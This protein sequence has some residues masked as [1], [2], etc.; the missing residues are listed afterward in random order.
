MSKE[1]EQR[2]VEM[3]F[4]NKQ[5]EQNVSTTMST[6]DKLKQKL[7]FTGASKG[8]E[9]ISSA[10]KKID[11]SG[12]ATG[13]ETIQSKF[14]ALEVVGVTALA[15]L[16][17]SAVNAGKRIASALTIDPVLTGFQEYETQMNA[18][19]TI[20]ANTSHQGTTLSQVN[21]ALDELNKYADQTIYNFT[22]MTRNI[23][24]FTAAG[25]DLDTS[26]GAIKGI[27]N[28]AA[29]SGSTATQASQAMYQLSQAIAAGQVTLQ[30][31]NSV[32][33][34]GMGG[35]VFQDALRDTAEAMGIAI[36]RTESFRES[37]STAGGR[38][39]WLTSEVLLNTLNQFTG[40]LTDAELAAMGFTE[41]QIKNIQEMAVT[42]N[43]AA[44]K[45]KTFTQLWDTLKESAQ[46]GWTETW[47]IMVGDFEEAKELLTELSEI[48]G[49]IIGQSAAN[50][51]TLLY[52]TMTS[53]WKK[54]TDEVNNAGLSVEDYKDKI[55]E[56][57]KSQGQPIDDLIKDYG[58]LDLAIR[59]GAVSSDILNTA[60][61][62]MTGTSDEITKK[63]NDL[64]LG[65]ENN[66]KN[67]RAL[68]N[69]G[70][71]YYNAQELLA[72]GTKDQV[73]ALNELSDS[74]LKNLGYTAEQI[75]G[76]RDLSQSAELAGGSLKT[77]MDNVAVQ[78]G[79][80]M[81]IDSLRVSIRSLIDI[82]GAAGKAWRDVFP[83]MTSDR[84]LEI[85]QSIRDFTLA[86]RPSE[87]TINKLQSTFRGLFSILSIAKQAISALLS[88]IG[89]LFGNFSN[90][91]GGIL[92]ATASFGDWLYTLDQSIKV[93]DSFGGVRDTITSVV[94][95]FGDAIDSIIGWF[96]GFDGVVSGVGDTVSRVFN[97]IKD[98]IGGAF[99]W[100][101][102]NISAGDIFAGLAGG[103]IF[104]AFKK[105][106]GLIDKVK[107]I[108]N[109][110]KDGGEGIAGGFS[111]ILGSVHDTLDGFSEGIQV[112]S[113]VGI[114]TAVALLT[115]SLRKISELEPEQ[116]AY[117][118]VTIRLLIASLNSGF[119]SLT[120]TLSKFNA[121][122]T[123]KASLAMIAIAE[124]INI[125][126]DAL[127]IFA[128]LSMEE[129]GRGLLTVAGT[130]IELTLALK[131][132]DGVKISLRTSLALIALAEACK[133]LSEALVGFAQLNLDEI[134][135][136]LS[137]MGGALL[138]LTVA[139]GILSKVGGGGALLGSVG[140]LIAV[141]S[142]DEISENLERLGKLSWD[143]IGRGLSAMG[144]A[145]LELT[146]ALGI[147]SKVGGF[148]AVLGG[149]AILIAVQSL[150]EI[151]ENLKRLGSLSWDE[152]GKGLTA[153][154]GAL[155]ELG[156]VTGALGKLAGFSGILGAGSLVIAVQSLEK[157][158]DALAKFGDMAWDAIGRGLSAMGGALL[159]VGAV[160][161]GLGKLAGISGLFGA[162]TIW[163]TV[164]GLEDLATAL[165]QFGE[166]QWDEI[167]RGLVAMGGALLEVSAIS[168][169]LGAL[170]GFAGI[171]G[172]ASIWITVQGLSDLADAL[173]KFA[174]M[175]WDEI[176]RG[177]SAMGGAMLETAIGGLLNTFSGFGAASIA[178]MAAPLGDLADSIKKWQGVTV[179]ERLGAQIGSLATGISAF[180]FS[181][182]GADAIAAVAVPI[183]SM[184]DSIVKW[185][186]IVI[187]ATLPAQLS[188]LAT[189][190]SAFN[191]SGWGAD[192][193]AAVAPALGTLA[194]SIAKWQKVEIPEGLPASLRD[195]A[196]GVNAF[197][198]A[199]IGGWSI[200]ALVGPLSDLADSVEKWNGVTI[201]ADMGSKLTSLADGCKAFNLSLFGDWDIED[202]VEP[203]GN[204][205]DSMRKWNGVSLSA[206]GPGLTEVANGLKTFAQ[207][208]LSNI[209]NTGIDAFIKSFTN[210]TSRIQTAANNMLNAFITAVNT[211]KAEVGTAFTL[212]LDDL[213]TQMNLKQGDFTTAAN[214]IMATIITAINTNRAVVRN[215]FAT[216]LTQT[217]STIRGYYDSFKSAGGYLASGFAN[218]IEDGIPAVE[219][220]AR[221]MARR[222]YQAAMAELNAA[223][224]SKLFTKVGTYVP[225]GFAK[226]I[227]QATPDVEDS[228]T[229][230]AKAAIASV[231]ST[232]SKIA[233]IVNSDIDAQPT[234][235]PVLDLS[236]VETEA[237]KLNTMFARNQVMSINA[238]MTR[239][240][241]ESIQN[242][243]QNAT[244]AGASFN[245]TQNNYSPKALSR[246]EIYRQTKNQFSAMERMV[247]A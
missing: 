129:I 200:S 65:L 94:K 81:L 204:L 228:A 2:V 230:M 35:K 188:A 116:I 142:L 247:R 36:D 225:M 199:F 140:I 240:P 151:S 24:T 45:V 191:F 155:T 192:A 214:S 201:P 168:G 185:Q 241:G 184:A 130:L 229:S 112:A 150:D 3:R 13:V 117:S 12:L 170:A 244:P 202:L 49:G 32:V 141:Q 224:P 93:G 154:G 114:A 99:N 90:L 119:K 38:E 59:N 134:D 92:D 42:A 176:G 89:N 48:F 243:D 6:L 60:L 183:G 246:V 149:T 108:F 148:G 23:G 197:S 145:L 27:A 69:M 179:P 215:S 231:S 33:N 171:L 178:K 1:I 64:D 20:L 177:L 97:A 52:D 238:S 210:A 156:V 40:D 180:N 46:S 139:L 4:D 235:R 106:S 120:K 236:N 144:G 181:G 11:V 162:G 169:G 167:G 76:I 193:I 218:G 242:G 205:A 172:G 239:T 174:L 72:K 133:M 85:I 137:A 16:A 221:R 124:A 56:T 143:E 17:N 26:V 31:W 8:L 28:L 237:G 58:S 39:S 83:P 115:S 161:G 195:L 227:D 220:V 62:A 147:L 198:F 209:A 212:V 123:I 47:E 78:Q 22:E 175:E 213:L 196:D 54:I 50:R 131:I 10:A 121:K 101:R 153:M 203:L 5:F 234:I 25:V 207:T 173:K 7:N 165:K 138:E 126:A 103:G 163:I 206:I 113:L 91:G 80:E 100:I 216:L 21:S 14:S 44:T 71:G 128:D 125:L 96:G 164:Q 67:L 88:P 182:W 41:A 30:D 55:V 29:V 217:V 135:R 111:D 166:M 73:I 226:G 82:F 158:A 37:I 232:I 222:A 87:E 34:A 15:N 211:K 136:G 132:I 84:L 79:R 187:P 61:L 160:S 66:N 19:Q 118:L 104:V 102:E 186:G 51:N 53:N 122:G 146:V 86:L 219:R 43:D 159:E 95:A 77:L 57:A 105:L 68:T 152:I 233:E 75:Q 190:V 157:L 18:V 245:F 189:G 194:D 9:N 208:N 107:D 74:Q 70:Y 63:M 110:F 127:V 98:T 223:S 109:I